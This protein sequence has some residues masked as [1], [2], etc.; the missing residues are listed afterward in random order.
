MLQFE[1]IVRP[2]WLVF[3]ID[4]FEDTG[5]DAKATHDVTASWTFQQRIQ[6][7]QEVH[8]RSAITHTFIYAHVD[9]VQTIVYAHPC[10]VD[11]FGLRSVKH[12]VK[13][14][15]VF[16]QISENVLTILQVT[17]CQRISTTG[18]LLGHDLL[19]RMSDITIA[20]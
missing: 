12:Y 14:I 13:L 5:I 17:G 10:N 2:L 4:V 8:R 16:W 19:K 3:L 6:S 20:R 1:G 15:M 7:E 18:F 9:I 11:S